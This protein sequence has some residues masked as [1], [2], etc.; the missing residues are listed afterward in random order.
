MPFGL[1]DLL[2]IV[3]SAS[4][5]LWAKRGDVV[6]SGVYKMVSLATKDAKK[7]AQ[8]AEV[9]TQHYVAPYALLPGIDIGETSGEVTATSTAANAAD[10][11]GGE[12][13]A[14][15][16]A[17]KY[18]GEAVR[19]SPC[20]PHRHFR[21]AKPGRTPVTALLSYAPED[22]VAS[23][24][25]Y[26]V[27]EVS[28]L[29]EVME[30][31]GSWEAA[32]NVT[33]GAKTGG[34]HA[35][36]I[37]KNMEMAVRTLLLAGE[38]QRAVDFVLVYASEMILSD[39]LL[40]ALFDA[41]RN[42][43]K[44]SLALYQS[45]KPFHSEWTPAVYA[46]CL[47]VNARFNWQEALNLYNEYM[48]QEQEQRQPLARFL[49]DVVCGTGI[50]GNSKGVEDGTLSSQRQSLKFVYHIIMP[51]VADRRTELLQKCYRQMVTHEPESAVVV[52]LRCLHTAAGRELAVQWLQESSEAACDIP[53]PDTRDVV[54]LAL[55]LYRRNPNVMNLNSLLKVIMAQ[56]PTTLHEHV[57]VELQQH[58]AVVDMTD[59]D[60]SV[61]ARTITDK[62]GHWKLASQFMSSMVTRKQFNV[63]SPLSYH[64]A[65][66]GRWSLASQAM[67]VCLS[68]RG[69]FTPAELCLCV[70][71]SVFAGRWKSAMFWMERAHS[72]GVR[73]PAA[74][75]DN[76]LGVTRHCSWASALRAVTS[77]HEAGGLSSEK[78]ILHVLES[79]AAQG[80]VRKALTVIAAT[81]N[82]YWTL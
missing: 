50:M 69:A 30:Q 21:R 71:S 31:E 32:L 3:A 78:G 75:Y 57:G 13:V 56:N 15:S 16:I 37:K 68:N 11:G 59:N 62:C 5:L 35:Y 48:E 54:K 6:R 27:V 66:Q 29:Y 7:A 53:P 60:A 47:T 41:C 65:R 77:M 73:L 72:H 44:N 18:V 9:A 67:A 80:Q 58:L 25:R 74:A 22:V 76:V 17:R 4:P 14:T 20:V 26:S 39:E 81:G 2:L 79:T 33:E 46:C 51:L 10:L 42:S 64:V 70:E 36:L 40:V 23:L 12:L 1:D 63:L 52:L 82:V 45:L 55:K 38:V 49:T 34:H 19:D 43:E 61:L 24:G 8:R 28:H